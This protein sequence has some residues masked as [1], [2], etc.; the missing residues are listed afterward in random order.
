MVLCV[1]ENLFKEKEGRLKTINELRVRYRELRR[2][3]GELA[4]NELFVGWI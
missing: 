3:K 1:N 2:N 4:L